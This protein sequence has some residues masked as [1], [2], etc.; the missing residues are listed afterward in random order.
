MKQLEQSEWY[1]QWQLLQDNEL[2]LFEDWIYPNRLED[3]KGKSVLECGC[4]G[5]QHTAFVAEYAKSVTAVDLNT[6]KIARER[7]KQYNNIEFIEDNIADM[8][9]NRQ[10]DVILAIGVVHHTNNPEKTVKNLIRHIALYGKII[11]WVYSKEGNYLIEKAVEPTRNRFLIKMSRRKLLILSKVITALIYLPIYSVYLLPFKFLPFYEYFQ[12]FRKLKFNRN[13]LNVFDKLNAPQ[14]IF[15]SRQRAM[16]WF[17][18]A[19]FSDIHI[20]CYKGISWRLS[21]IKAK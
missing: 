5:G 12:N 17:D 1:E 21:V 10:F 3:F 13:V 18:P 20:S 16:R 11:L 19:I 8:D 4:G 7:T 6:T 9:L 14:V 15:I 2:F